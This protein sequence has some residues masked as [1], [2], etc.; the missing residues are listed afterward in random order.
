MDPEGDELH[1]QGSGSARSQE[2]LAM[3]ELHKVGKIPAGQAFLQPLWHEREFG[4][5]HRG[6]A[7]KISP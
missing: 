7:S 6:V 3:D 5:L 4:S 1:R 2:V